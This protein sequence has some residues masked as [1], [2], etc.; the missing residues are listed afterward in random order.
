MTQTWVFHR[1]VYLDEMA[2]LGVQQLL[3][4]LMVC[5]QKIPSAAA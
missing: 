2:K 4:K 1:H 5:R 3:D